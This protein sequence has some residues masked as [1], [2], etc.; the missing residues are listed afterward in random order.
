VFSRSGNDE[1]APKSA[2][3]YNK[4]LAHLLKSLKVNED[5]RQQELALRIISACP[6]LVCGCVTSL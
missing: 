1:A 4:I 5:P 3:I 6:E 2:R